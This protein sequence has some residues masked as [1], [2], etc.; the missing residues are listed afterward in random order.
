LRGATKGRF[1]ACG[2]KGGERIE[3]IKIGGIAGTYADTDMVSTGPVILTRDWQQYTIDLE[4]SDLSYISGGFC[5]A[6]NLDVNPDGC[7][8]YFDDI[9]YE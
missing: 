8:F 1:W 2:E 7:T 3:E 5:W 4:G 9:R 6:T